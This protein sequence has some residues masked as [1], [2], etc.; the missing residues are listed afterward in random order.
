MSTDKTSEIDQIMS[1]I[2]KLRDQLQLINEQSK[3]AMIE[4]SNLSRKI[5]QTGRFPNISRRSDDIMQD[6]SIF[7]EQVYSSDIQSVLQVESYTFGPYT[8]NTRMRELEG[9]GVRTKLTQKEMFLLAIFAANINTFVDRDFC[10]NAIWRENSYLKSRSMDV[11][12][13]KIRNLIQDE[14]VN[15]V[16]RHGK[17][18]ILLVSTDEQTRNVIGG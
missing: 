10:L 5:K 12:I 16:N 18:Y 13:C 7:N 4:M 2:Q 14:Q 15:L 11:Y 1:D 8:L 6:N 9:K 17:G 3:L